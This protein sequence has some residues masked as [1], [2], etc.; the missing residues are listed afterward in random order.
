MCLTGTPPGKGAVMADTSGMDEQAQAEQFDTFDQADSSVPDDGSMTQE[1]MPPD[2]LWGAEAYGAGGTETEDAVAQRAARENPDEL[3]GEQ[4][5]VA[6]AIYEREDG[7]AEDDE[8]QMVGELDNASPGQL[9][10]EEAAM[11]VV[12]EEYAVRA[13]G[14]D[15]DGPPGDGYVD[16]G[17][18]VRKADD[19]LPGDQTA[20][21]P[22]RSTAER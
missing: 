16:V 2:T 17:G 12:D 19:G 5:Q 21:D 22:G 3:P 4:A 10:A 11:H 14:L 1:E 8:S 15:P 18:D 9:S 6:A 7:L 20:A 13:A